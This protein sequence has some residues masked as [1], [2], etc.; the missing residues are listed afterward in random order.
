MLFDIDGALLFLVV[1]FRRLFVLYSAVVE[2]R[3]IPGLPR[4]HVIYST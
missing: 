2:P 4:F 3:L 1:M